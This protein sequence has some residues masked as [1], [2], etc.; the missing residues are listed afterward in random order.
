VTKEWSER[1]ITI[2]AILGDSLFVGYRAAEAG[3]PGKRLQSALQVLQVNSGSR[4]NG[5]G[6]VISSAI[7][8]L[9]TGTVHDGARAPAR[10]S[11]VCGREAFRNFLGR[12]SARTANLTQLNLTYLYRTHAQRS[13]QSADRTSTA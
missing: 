9:A 10:P 11:P 5:G 12:P 7:A 3:V 6:L 8:P 4:G 1:V 13:R 2:S